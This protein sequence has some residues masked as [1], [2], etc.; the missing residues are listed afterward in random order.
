MPGE[1]IDLSGRASDLSAYITGQTVYV[2]GGWGAGDQDW[3]G[4]GF[5]RTWCNA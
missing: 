2:D 1:T 3:Q 5:P 4:P